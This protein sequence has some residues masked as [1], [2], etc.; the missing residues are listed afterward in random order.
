MAVV[1]KSAQEIGTMREAGRIVAKTLADVADKV[2]PGISTQELDKIANKAIV[3]LGGVPSFKGYRGYPAT[4]CLSINEEVVHGIPG[5]VFCGK[6][7]SFHWM[8]GPS[9]RDI[10]A[11]PLLPYRWAR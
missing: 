6:A 11:T 10:R 5:N 9:I 4:I 8:L 3:S 7:T 2:R 1:L